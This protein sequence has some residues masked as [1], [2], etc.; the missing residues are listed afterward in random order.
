MFRIGESPPSERDGG[1][2]VRGRRAKKTFPCLFLPPERTKGVLYEEEFLYK[3]AR[4]GVRRVS[5]LHIY[6]FLTRKYTFLN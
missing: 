1:E 2:G 5:G 4:T 3:Y 6:S